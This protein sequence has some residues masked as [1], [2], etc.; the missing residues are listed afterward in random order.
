MRRLIFDA[1]AKT[2][3][4]GPLEETLRWGEPAYLTTHSK[5]GSTVRIAWKQAQPDRYG[6]YF[7]CQTNLVATFKQLYPDAFDY[8]GNRGISFAAADA[9]PVDELRHCITLAL[10]YHLDKR[11][12]A[13][14]RR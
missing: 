8:D 3:G 7:H 4:V 12:A 6:V 13:G 14:R 1:A 10:T 11:R 9:V 2:D 5:S